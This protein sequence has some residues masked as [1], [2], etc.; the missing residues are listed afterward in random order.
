VA[1]LKLDRISTP[2]GGPAKAIGQ[3]CTPNSPVILTIGSMQVGS[4]TANADGSFTADLHLNVPVGQY[5]VVAVCG[6]TLTA[7]IDVVLSS[8]ANTPTSTAAILL[9]LLMV[10][11]ALGRSQFSSR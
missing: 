4:T 3:G 5:Q 11:L 2:P 6:P 1:Q 9:I 10:I 7:T 8:Q